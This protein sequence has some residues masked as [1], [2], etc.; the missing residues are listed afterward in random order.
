MTDAEDQEAIDALD[1]LAGMEQ[2][3]PVSEHREYAMDDAP[4][5]P[6]DFSRVLFVTLLIVSV[7]IILS[8][9]PDDLVHLPACLQHFFYASTI[10]KSFI[11]AVLVVIIL[12]TSL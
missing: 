9:I 11:L 4:C 1:D 2:H 5:E 3:Q 12:K 6:P 8:V 7:F 10:V